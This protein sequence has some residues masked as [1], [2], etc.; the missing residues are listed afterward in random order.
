MTHWVRGGLA[1]LG[2]NFTLVVVYWDR[3]KFVF[4]LGLCFGVGFLNFIFGL[5]WQ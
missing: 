4:L 1:K 2:L 5:Y 3:R